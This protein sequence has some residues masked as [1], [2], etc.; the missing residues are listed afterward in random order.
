MFKIKNMIEL[1][2]KIKF[3]TQAEKLFI[4]AG[5]FNPDLTLNQNELHSAL[6]NTINTLT[7]RQS[8]LLLKLYQHFSKEGLLPDEPAIN[9]LLANFVD[10]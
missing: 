4:E 10:K 3:T 6:V 8:P 5:G 1:N 7:E 2:G 9:K